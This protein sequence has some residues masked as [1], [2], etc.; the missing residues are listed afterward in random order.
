MASRPTSVTTLLQRRLRHLA[1]AASHHARVADLVR[2]ALPREL[3]GRC[4][5]A[6]IDGDELVLYVDSPGWATRL[7]FLAPRLIAH[8]AAHGITCRRARVRVQPPGERV[9][10][11]APA[12]KTALPGPDAVRAVSSAAATAGSDAL[13][14]ALRRLARSLARRQPPA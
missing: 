2:E 6:L 10:P 7:R 8:L 14:D 4:L 11:V 9:A 13:A 1:D 5:G 3:S 12:R